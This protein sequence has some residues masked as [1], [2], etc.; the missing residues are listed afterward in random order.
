MR[1]TYANNS[2]F[3]V[4]IQELNREKGH[5][6]ELS[7]EEDMGRCDRGRQVVTFEVCWKLRVA[8]TTKV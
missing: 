1:I 6:L 3:Y 8:S 7:I 4:L 2:R 5:I